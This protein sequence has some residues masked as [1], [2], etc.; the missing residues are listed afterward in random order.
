MRF[1]VLALGVPLA[2]ACSV[3]SGV[4]TPGTDDIDTLPDAGASRD[5]ATDAASADSGPSDATTPD[6]SPADASV[7]EAAPADSGCSCGARSVC[8]QNACSAARRVF[9]ASTA[10]NANLGGH[11][12]ADGECGSIASAQSLGGTW[13]AWVSDSNSSPSTRFSRSTDPYRLLD[14]TLVANDWN[15][16]TSGSI[17]N[18]INVTEIGS[19]LNG[20]PVWTSTASDGSY[21]AAGCSDLSSGSSSGGSVTVGISTGTDITWTVNSTDPCNDTH[22]RIYCF[23][24]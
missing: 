3:D 1:L 4:T 10:S 6:S 15:D 23:E 17:A 19:I 16:L 12:G 11:S 8:V 18:A 13:K 2:V 14:G 20:S 21:I 7:A 9:L 5:A 22:P 24:Q